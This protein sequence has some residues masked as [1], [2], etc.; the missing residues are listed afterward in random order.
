MLTPKTRADCV[1]IEDGSHASAIKWISVGW[2]GRVFFIKSGATRGMRPDITL[3]RSHR[4][5]VPDLIASWNVNAVA[6]RLRWRYRCILGRELGVDG[7]TR[8]NETSADS[9]GTLQYRRSCPRCLARHCCASSRCRI[10]PPFERNNN[11]PISVFFCWSHT[12]T[13]THSLCSEQAP[14]ILGPALTHKLS[15]TLPF[16]RRSLRDGTLLLIWATQ[17]LLTALAVH[18]HLFQSNGHAFIAFNREMGMFAG[19]TLPRSCGCCAL[20]TVGPF[21]G[22]TVRWL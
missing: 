15:D 4:N 21:W 22:L 19:P 12:H 11:F 18:Q 2:K 9:L 6:Q 7:V 5:S 17:Q 8:C 20:S 13:R 14:I 16:P 3:P 10:V 1:S